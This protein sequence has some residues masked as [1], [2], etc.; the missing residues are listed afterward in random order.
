M[1]DNFFIQLFKTLRSKEEIK[2]FESYLKQ[3]EKRNLIPLLRYLKRFYPEFRYDKK[4]ETVYIFR[5]LYER[6]E[7][8][9][10]IIKNKHK[11]ILNQLSELHLELN[12]FLIQKKFREDHLLYELLH[13]QVLKERGLNDRFFRKIKTLEKEIVERPKPDL[14]NDLN[15]VKF[16]DTLLG[17]SRFRDIVHRTEMLRKLM[18]SLSNFS[19]GIGYKFG[20]ALQSH[21]EILGNDSND[22]SLFL[23]KLAEMGSIPPFANPLVHAYVLGYRL[24]KDKTDEAFYLLKEFNF[25]EKGKMLS[26]SD[27]NELLTVLINFCAKKIRQKEDKYNYEIFNLYKFGLEEELLIDGNDI[28]E[29][30]F[31]NIIS[32]ACKLKEFDWVKFFIKKYD[33]YL[34]VS[35]QF[36]VVQISMAVVALEK[37]QSRKALR[38]IRKTNFPHPYQKLRARML[39]IRARY[40]LDDDTGGDVLNECRNLEHFLKANK[41][42]KDQNRVLT[43]NFVKMVTLLEKRKLSKDQVLEKFEKYKPV[44]YQDWIEDKLASYRKY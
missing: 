3:S 31:M 21:N 7:K 24:E 37:G 13:L 38:I 26:N 23:L 10:K 18:Q 34:H 29:H 14:Q 27:R 12:E 32:V 8:N 9:R 1:G 33:N 43:L 42:I 5:R 36:Y 15:K 40:D 16:Y 25:S 6:D 30:K 39:S 19:L 11:F 28:S 2:E 35:I 4:L 20:T 22:P 17:H 44:F 41:M